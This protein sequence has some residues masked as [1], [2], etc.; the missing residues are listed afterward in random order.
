MSGGFSGGKASAQRKNKLPTMATV[1]IV[2]AGL[3]W[4]SV[5]VYRWIADRDGLGEGEAGGGVP[6]VNVL[7]VKR[8][9]FEDVLSAV[10]NVVGGSE[11]PLRFEVEGTIAQLDFREGDKMRKGD[12]IARLNQRDAFLKMK[13][14]ELEL[15]QAEKLFALDAIAR[16]KLE[17]ARLAYELARSDLDKTVIRATR[18]GILGGK[19]A[20]PGEFV[21]PNKIIA[22]LVSIETVVVDVGIIER[23]IDKIFPGQKVVVTVDAYPG[24]EF[25]GK[26]E[27]LDTIIRGNSRTLT[28]KA[29]LK[30]EGGLLLPGM[31][32]RTKIVVREEDDAISVPNDAIEKTQAGE[33][34]LVVNKENKAEAR[35]IKVDYKSTQ[36]SLVSSGLKPGE[37]VIVQRPQDL[38]EGSP[39]KVIDVQK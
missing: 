23:E 27:T 9:P 21:T 15:D 19:E 30:N 12:I 22:T 29:R 26:V 25:A 16:S 28:V 33:Q 4:G 14:A 10:G 2:L 3:M 7:E 37:Q 11:I 17:E 38:K 20:E 6:A 35:A 8:A 32:A 36:F 18:D 5:K 13:R 24:V 39:V 31:F 34:V 1:F